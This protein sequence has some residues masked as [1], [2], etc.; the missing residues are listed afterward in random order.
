[1]TDPYAMEP[2]MRSLI[3]IRLCKALARIKAGPLDKMAWQDVKDDMLTIVHDIDQ[4]I[5]YGNPGAG[6]DQLLGS[7]DRPVNEDVT[8]G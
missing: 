3:T 6:I 8:N 5:D 7:K 1:M 2:W 4:T